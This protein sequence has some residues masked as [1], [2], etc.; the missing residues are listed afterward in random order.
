ML[1]HQIDF[2]YAF[3]IPGREYLFMLESYHLQHLQHFIIPNELL[4]ISGH[5]FTVTFFVSIYL[6]VVFIHLYL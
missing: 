3:M 2:F 6:L 1:L 5:Y 4:Y